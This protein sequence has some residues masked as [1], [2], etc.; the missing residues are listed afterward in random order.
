ME[1][2]ISSLSMVELY[3]LI[4]AIRLHI[5]HCGGNNPSADP[6]LHKDGSRVLK[7]KGMVGFNVENL[8]QETEK[9]TG[10]LR[11]KVRGLCARLDDLFFHF[12]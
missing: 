10:L 5:R 9:L 12:S 1:S 8:L 6:V 7:T 4:A 11:K 2:A 3:L